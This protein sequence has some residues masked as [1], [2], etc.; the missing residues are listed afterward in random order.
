MF[1]DKKKDISTVA[2][3]ILITIGKN[4][5]IV[6]TINKT[7]KKKINEFFFKGILSIFIYL[8]TGNLHINTMRF[9]YP[10]FTDEESEFRKV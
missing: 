6:P 3:A 5:F 8:I 1:S 4:D 7:I 2:K 10:P 9:F